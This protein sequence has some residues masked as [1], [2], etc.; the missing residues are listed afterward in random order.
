M[1]EKP[2]F[3]KK[4]EEV[5]MKEAIAEQYELMQLR[6]T[7]PFDG[8]TGQHKAWN[9]DSGEEKTLYLTPVKNKS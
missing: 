2:Y 3:V 9:L 7:Y 4:L 1:S 8:L 5:E 6:K